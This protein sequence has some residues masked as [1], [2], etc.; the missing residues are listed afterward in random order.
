M[1]PIQYFISIRLIDFYF[2]FCKKDTTKVNEMYMNLNIKL[3]YTVTKVSYGNIILIYKTT[4]YNTKQA[5]SHATQAS[6]SKKCTDVHIIL[7][8]TSLTL[9]M[10][11]QTFIKG[12]N[13]Y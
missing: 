12:R 8:V 3:V 9:T 11:R 7:K 1:F 13:V 6:T 2:P 4:K 5:V 10:L